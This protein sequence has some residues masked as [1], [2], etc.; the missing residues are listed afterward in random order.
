MSAFVRAAEST[1][2]DI[3]TSFVDF[4]WGKDAPSDET[5]KRYSGRM[6]SNAVDISAKVRRSPSFVFLGGSVD[7]GLF[8]NCFG[9]AN[10]F[11]RRSAFL[12]L[13]GYSED[14][15]LGYE[16]WELYA[17]AAY[18]GFTLEVVPEALYHYRFT[19]GSMQ[20]STSYSRS[21]KRAL[22]AYT[23]RL[24]RAQQ[25]TKPF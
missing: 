3:F 1:G 4:I 7:V 18:A 25:Q 23:E 21:R 16:D 2:G 10:S 19:A 15:K 8:K 12:A 13:G 14:R 6:G 20:K 24:Q 22:R 17:R 9:D 11:Y 5:N